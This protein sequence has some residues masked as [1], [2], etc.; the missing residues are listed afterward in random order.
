MIGEELPSGTIVIRQIVL[1]DN[2]LL[3]GRTQ[4]NEKQLDNLVNNAQSLMIQGGKP[5]LFMGHTHPDQKHLNIPNRFQNSWSFGDL[6]SAFCASDRYKN[7]NIQVINVLIT[8]SMDINFMFYDR[9]EQSF[10]RFN[11]GIYTWDKSKNCYLPSNCYSDP[12][13]NALSYDLSQSNI[14]I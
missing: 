9:N 5:I 14:R 13:A 2:N 6:Y 7:D 3:S 1:A 4:H 8:P 12:D 10:Y 11:E